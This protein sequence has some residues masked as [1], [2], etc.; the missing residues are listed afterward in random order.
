MLR[1]FVAF[2]L[3]KLAR[4]W[5]DPESG[6]FLRSQRH[7]SPR[8]WAPDDTEAFEIA[9]RALLD[10]GVLGSGGVVAKDDWRLRDD[11]RYLPPAEREDLEVWLME[12]A[13][14]Y[15]LALEDRPGSPDDWLEARAILD[16]V[17]GQRSIRAFGPL[18]ARL[19]SRLGTAEAPGVEAPD[20]PSAPAWLD[21]HLLGFVAECQSA[22][23]P[24]PG[25][26]ADPDGVR[27]AAIERA[28]GHYEQARWR[29]GPA[30]SGRTTAPRRPASAW[31]GP[32][33]PRNTW[34]S[35]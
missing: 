20:S 11:V 26:T 25:S 9:R 19:A 2:A 28:L 31:A 10:Y 32:P 27:R 1:E 7:S 4:K 16:R 21:E 29:A 3:G 8:A 6:A 30:R 35:P 34:R 23:D 14:R 24:D 12:R 15:G 33:R 22:S 18:R 17:D 5:D 13:Y